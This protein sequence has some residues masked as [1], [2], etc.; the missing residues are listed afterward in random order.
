MITLD[1]LSLPIRIWTAA[2]LYAAFA[3]ASLVIAP[4]PSGSATFWPI[5]GLFV[6]ALLLVPPA[7]RLATTAAFGLAHY[8]GGFAGSTPPLAHFGFSWLVAFEAWLAASVIMA[9]DS[10]P[11][12]F[13]HLAD[14]GRLF[15]GGCVVGSGV[16]GLLGGSLANAIF[17]DPLLAAWREWWL[18]DAVGMLVATPL[19]VRAAAGEWWKGVTARR[20]AEGLVL[21]AGLFAMAWYIFRT[22]LPTVPLSVGVLPFLVWAALRFGVAGIS[23]AAMIVWGIA[24]FAIRAGQGPFM[25]LGST[26]AARLA[27]SHVYVAVTGGSVLVIAAI[28]AERQ[29]VSAKLARSVREL[30][31]AYARAQ[32]LIASAPDM[33][34]AVDDAFHIIAFNQAWAVEFEHVTGYAPSTGLDLRQALQSRGTPWALSALGDWERA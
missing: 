27:W 5:S 33:L 12:R 20:V 28:M 9:M 14:V 3:A 8:V 19:V 2:A 32:A 13:N 21:L 18:P 31:D 23:A 11:L 24:V 15:I 29:L 34:V 25:T 4:G 30:R 17:G 7:Q 6:A 10:R 16:G 1:R 26:D 22:E